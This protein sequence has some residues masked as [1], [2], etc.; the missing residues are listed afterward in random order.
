MLGK[1]GYTSTMT[2]RSKGTNEKTSVHLD[3]SR[4]IGRAR[5][6][7]EED[8]STETDRV[9]QGRGKDEPQGNEIVTYQFTRWRTKVKPSGK[10]YNRKK[11]DNYGDKQY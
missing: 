10:L 6:L 5:D 11:K 2:T 4:R 1:I 8:R 3:T 7:Q 9:S